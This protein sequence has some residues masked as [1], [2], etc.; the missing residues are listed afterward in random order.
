MKTLT[1]ILGTLAIAGMLT[2]GAGFAHKNKE[3]FA[4]GTGAFLLGG[5]GYV[6]VKSKEYEDKLNYK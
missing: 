1:K 2:V 5:V 3:A 6:L 4:V